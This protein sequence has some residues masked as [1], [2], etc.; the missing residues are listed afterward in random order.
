MDEGNSPEG[1]F[2]DTCNPSYHGLPNAAI[3]ERKKNLNEEDSDFQPRELTS[4]KGVV[5]KEYANTQKE[6]TVARKV[7]ESTD[8]KRG[9]PLTS[10]NPRRFKPR[11]VKGYPQETR[12]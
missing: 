2:E 8:A 1:S 5:R 6:R 11:A 4:K 7:S 10:K 12:Q 9:I 3:R